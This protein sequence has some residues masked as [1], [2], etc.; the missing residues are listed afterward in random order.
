MA[1]V[2]ILTSDN[3][4]FKVKLVK[5]DKDG[6]FILRKWA[7]HQEKKTIITLYETNVSAPDFF[8]HTL[9]DLNSI[10]PNTVVVWDFNPSIEKSS[11]QTNLQRNPRTKWH[12]NLFIYLN[13]NNRCLQ[14]NRCPLRNT[15]LWRK[16]NI[17]YTQQP[18]EISLK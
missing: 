8:K 14:R 7:I 3:V 1:G 4:H 15:C 18:M 11:R 9:K 17:Y 6:H 12:G 13:G 2:S 10:D 16:H 5:R